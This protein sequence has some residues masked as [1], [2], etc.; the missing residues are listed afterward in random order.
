MRKRQLE[1]FSQAD[2]VAMCTVAGM[3]DAHCVGSNG[4]ITPKHLVDILHEV[5]RR[6]I[7]VQL[8]YNRFHITS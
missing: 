8:T 1:A 5:R 7:H 2:C 6:W 3:L 4:D